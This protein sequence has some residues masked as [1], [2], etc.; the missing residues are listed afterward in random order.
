MAFELADRDGDGSLSLWEFTLALRAS[1]VVDSDADAHKEWLATDVDGS[2]AVEWPEF[3]ALGRRRKA[4][5]TLAERLRAEPVQS[6]RAA[7]LIQSHSRRRLMLAAARRHD[8]QVR[9]AQDTT[10]L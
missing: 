6:E 9:Q 8:G 3:R 5:A 1:G 4:L 10:R 2:G 7:V